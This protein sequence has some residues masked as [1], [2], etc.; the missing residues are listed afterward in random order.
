MLEIRIKLNNEQADVIGVKE[1]LAYICENLGD[2]ALIDVAEIK[3]LQTSL[4][5][6]KNEEK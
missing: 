2:V 3:P 6:M 5:S 4:F 1:T